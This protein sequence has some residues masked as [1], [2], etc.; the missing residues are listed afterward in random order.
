MK[1]IFFDTNIILDQLDDSRKGH[2]DVKVL[3][4]V[5]GQVGAQALCAWH[6]LSIV[7]Y[8]GKKVFPEEI[9]SQVLHGIVE[10]FTIPKTGTEEAKQAFSYLSGDYEDAMQTSSAMAG[11]ADFFVTMTKKDF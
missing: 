2:E 11:R 4:C 10:H 5:M 6:S 8:I 1:R 3:E 9:L 7:E